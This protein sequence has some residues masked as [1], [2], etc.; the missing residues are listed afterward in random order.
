MTYSVM[1]LRHSPVVA[2]LVEGF[3]F[4]AKKWLFRKSA[5]GSFTPS[6]CACAHV[7]M[8]AVFY[9]IIVVEERLMKL[10]AYMRMCSAV[11][12]V[13]THPTFVAFIKPQPLPGD[14]IVREI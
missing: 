2:E 11:S 10:N 5:S 3:D 12:L 9:G 1:Q 7:F 8:H 14:S 4:P 6:R 13:S